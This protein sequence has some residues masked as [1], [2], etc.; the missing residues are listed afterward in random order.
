MSFYWNNRVVEVDNE[1]D[2]KYYEICEVHYDENDKPTGYC[3]L[4][5]VGSDTLEGLKAVYERLGEAL[6][7]PILNEKDFKGE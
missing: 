5:C 7:Q 6:T 4:I 1:N 2:E 3:S